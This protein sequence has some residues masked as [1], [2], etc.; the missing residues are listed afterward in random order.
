[1]LWLKTS[2]HLFKS[3]IDRNASFT[4]TL[5][6]LGFQKFKIL[7]T[8]AICLACIIFHKSYWFLHNSNPLYGNDFDDCFKNNEGDKNNEGVFSLHDTP[9]DCLF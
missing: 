4:E 6:N 1:M 7:I 5:A 9:I 3:L 8:M 2:N